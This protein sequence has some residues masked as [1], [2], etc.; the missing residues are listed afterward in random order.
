MSGPSENVPRAIAKLK[1]LAEGGENM[2]IEEIKV[3]PKHH[4]YLVGRGGATRQKM[5]AESGVSRI[6]I[7]GRK[8]R[9]SLGCLLASHVLAVRPKSVL[10]LGGM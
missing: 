10:T 8:P 5:E 3:D 6:V 1:S 4:R 9:V 7:P 2:S